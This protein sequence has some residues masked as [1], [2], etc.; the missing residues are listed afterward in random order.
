MLP[1][2][3]K[4]EGSEVTSGF[5]DEAS[6]VMDTMVCTAVVRAEAQEKGGERQTKG[7]GL[8]LVASLAGKK[9]K[10]C[11]RDWEE[12]AISVDPNLRAPSCAGLVNFREL[13]Q[14]V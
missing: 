3:K 13:Y 8:T 9:P 11:G 5:G 12:N 6:P 7:Q 10:K 14:F 4:E 2:V 1:R